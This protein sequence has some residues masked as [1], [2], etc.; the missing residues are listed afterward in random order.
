M[1]S[2][3][4]NL[5]LVCNEKLQFD[6]NLEELQ[7]KFSLLYYFLFLYIYIVPDSLSLLSFVLFS[8]KEKC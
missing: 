8:P 5:I 1:T 2:M 4:N 3:T 6:S 7:K